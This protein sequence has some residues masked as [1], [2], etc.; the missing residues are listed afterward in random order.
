MSHYKIDYTNDPN[1][2]ATAIE[3]IKKWLG[4][5]KFNTLNEE[6]AKVIHELALDH[7]SFYCSFAGISGF[8][9]KVWY[10]KLKGGIR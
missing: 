3:D 2:E 4:E 6:F 10:E 1:A 5:E 9:V 8:P 7:F